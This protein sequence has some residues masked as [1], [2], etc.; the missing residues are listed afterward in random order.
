M[1]TDIMTE[2]E[3]I[4]TNEEN[5][6]GVSLYDVQDSLRDDL[7]WLGYDY[8]NTLIS[9]SV[10]PYLLRNLKMSNFLKYLNDI[11][12]EYVETV[13]KVRVYYN[14]TV[15]KEYRNIN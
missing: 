8:K 9:N 7:K 3:N 13:K 4:A 1:A 15:N 12:V 10:S 14:F 11:A 6:G 2:F 5:N